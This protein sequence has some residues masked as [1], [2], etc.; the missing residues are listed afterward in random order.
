MSQKLLV[1]L[2]S[3]ESD[4]LNISFGFKIISRNSETNEKTVILGKM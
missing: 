3:M 1:K 4:F 2:T